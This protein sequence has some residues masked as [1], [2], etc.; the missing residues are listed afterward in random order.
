MSI[1]HE[2]IILIY[3]NSEAIVINN[4]SISLHEDNTIKKVK[5]FIDQI[6]TDHKN[7]ILYNMSQESKIYYNQISESNLAYA[8]ATINRQDLAQVLIL[9]H[10]QENVITRYD[11]PTDP[12]KTEFNKLESA[13]FNRKDNSFTLKFDASQN[14]IPITN[15]FEEDDNLAYWI[16]IYRR[17]ANNRNHLFM[18]GEMV[19]QGYIQNYLNNLAV[20]ELIQ[21]VAEYELNQHD[22]KLLTALNNAHFMPYELFN[23]FDNFT[24]EQILIR[25]TAYVRTHVI[26]DKDDNFKRSM[27]DQLI[28]VINDT[29]NITKD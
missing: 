22:N 1:M 17:I 2:K 24:Y 16:D 14:M 6:N 9:D 20:Y 15:R 28:T 27:R 12:S 21:F 4:A 25:F 23:Q 29:K 19:Y 5:F 3:F 7:T 10:D 18:Q 11:V 13:V 26:T 8:I